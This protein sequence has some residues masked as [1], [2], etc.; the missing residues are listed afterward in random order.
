MIA[1]TGHAGKPLRKEGGDEAASL[2]EFVRSAKVRLLK[3]PDSQSPR[4][5]G[6]IEKRKARAGTAGLLALCASENRDNKS[7]LSMNPKRCPLPCL[8]FNSPPPPPT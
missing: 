8:S 2:R 5:T 4:S 1:G 7:P 6:E 3:R